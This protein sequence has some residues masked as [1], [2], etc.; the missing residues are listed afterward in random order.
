MSSFRA[1]YEAKLKELSAIGYSAKPKINVLTQIAAEHQDTNA[2][3]VVDCIVAH[4][5]EVRFLFAARW[6][7]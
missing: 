7:V 5:E 1:Q 4:F 3:D 2:Q 6:F